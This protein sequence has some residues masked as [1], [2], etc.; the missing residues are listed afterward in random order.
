[1]TTLA[2]ISDE[3]AGGVAKAMGPWVRSS[4]LGR[5]EAAGIPVENPAALDHRIDDVAE[6][7]RALVCTGLA[8][9]FAADIDEQRTSPLQVVRTAVPLVTNLLEELGVPPVQRDAFA[10]SAFPA[11]LYDLS[12][13]AFG[14]LSP[15]LHDLGLA[16]GAAKAFTHLQRRR[17]EADR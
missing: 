6:R 8:E 17:G 10:A 5:L 14:D 13:V 4:V 3:L 2:S 15:D 9:L 1:M 16:W 12:P 11:D 7:C